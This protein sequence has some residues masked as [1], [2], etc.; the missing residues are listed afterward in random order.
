M[1]CGA[2]FYGVEGVLTC[3]AGVFPVAG[4][5]KAVLKCSKMVVRGHY[6][7][8]KECLIKECE[9]DGH[10]LYLYDSNLETMMSSTM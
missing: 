9:H 1:R 8:Y 5:S 2:S 7:S 4:R 6:S 3:D 10:A